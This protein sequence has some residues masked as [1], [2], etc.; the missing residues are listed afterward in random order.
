MLQSTPELELK[1]GLVLDEQGRILSTREPRATRGPLFVII[2]NAAACAFAIRAGLPRN[3]SLE[4]E[5]LAREESPTPNLRDEPTHA[6]RYLSLLGAER[7]FCGP[8]FEFP[9][10][11]PSAPDVTQVDDERLLQRHFPGW[12]RSDMAAGRSPVCAVIEQGYAVSICFCA[13]RSEAAAAA[14]L[15]TA[16]P[17]RGRGLAERVTAAWASAIRATGRVPL[18]SADWSNA[19][20]RSVARKLGLSESASFWSVGERT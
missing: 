13:R 12:K 14:G 3:L 1:T 2:R 6:E 17:F 15:E 10:V 7:G 4:L 5:A 16:P 20:S 11:L 18:Y 8:A 9:Q 19:A